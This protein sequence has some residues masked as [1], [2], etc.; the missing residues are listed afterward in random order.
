MRIL[1]VENEGGDADL[2]QREL[3]A[4]GY[5]VVLARE[6]GDGERRAIGDRVDLV[7][8]D[9][10]MPNGMSA[11][12]SIR[13]EKPA[14]PVIALSDRDDVEHKVAGL[15]GGASDYVTKPFALE[16]LTA[17]IRAQLRAPRNGEATRLEAGGISLDLLAREVTVGGNTV[18]LS[19]REFELLTYFM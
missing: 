19:S 8:L 16:E 10:K 17:R 7:L 12:G 18:H 5:A 13:R 9:L 1:V 14:L 2:M 15:D 11:L 6:A 4:Q 3:A